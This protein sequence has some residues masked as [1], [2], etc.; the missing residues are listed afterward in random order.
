M[1]TNR[2]ATSLETSAWWEVQALDPYSRWVCVSDHPSREEAEE[3]AFAG[4]RV[5]RKR[6]L[7]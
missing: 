6:G 4:E 5:V 7:A 1:E 3:R 2:Q